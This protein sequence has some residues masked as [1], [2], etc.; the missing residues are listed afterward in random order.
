MLAN[1]VCN[2]EGP[3]ALCDTY[4]YLMGDIGV[5]KGEWAMID[6]CKM[7]ASCE[8]TS[9]GRCCKYTHSLPVAAEAQAYNSNCG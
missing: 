8:A 7:S 2:W 3:K 4:S 9:I 1:M 5:C 6:R